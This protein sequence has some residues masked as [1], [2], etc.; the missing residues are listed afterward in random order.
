[1]NYFTLFP[2]QGYWG[3]FVGLA[4]SIVSLLLLLIYTLAGPTFLLKVFSPEKQLV[5]L[6]WLFSIGLF[7]LSFSKE[8]IDDERVQLVRYTALRGMVLMC[9]IGL[10]SSFSPLMIDDLGMSLMAKGSTLALVLMVIVAPLLTYQVIFNIGLHLNT[11]WVY[12]DLSAEDNLKKNP[13]FFLFYI[14][15]ITLLLTGILILNV[16][17]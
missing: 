15:F 5:S 12:N 13:K 2:L 14:I 1:M 8:K 7:M 11:D 3:K 17:K 16:L 10:F 4:I 9:F 6:L